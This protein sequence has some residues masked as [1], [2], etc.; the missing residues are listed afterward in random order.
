MGILTLVRMILT[1]DSP[2]KVARVA[3]ALTRRPYGAARVSAARKSIAACVE[4][5]CG[6]FTVED[7]TLR[8]RATDVRAGATA[9]VYRAVASLEA[10]GYLERIGRRQGSILYTRCGQP[11]HHH[12]IICEQCGTTT[13]ASCPVGADLLEAARAAGFT[14]TRHSVTLY[15]LCPSCARE[16]SA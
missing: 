3:D 6:A 12:H 11:D 16:A 8:V 1:R 7:L 13:A 5:F 10:S 9:T 2:T 14:L 4:E 15:G